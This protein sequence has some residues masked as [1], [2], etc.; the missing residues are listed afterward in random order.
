MGTI[1]DRCCEKCACWMSR[2]PDEN[3]CN[4][5]GETFC[6]CARSKRRF[7]ISKFGRQPARRPSRQEGSSG[8]GGSE[9]DESENASVATFEAA[10][11]LRRRS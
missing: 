1:M 6:G 7:S 3:R 5:C 2:K 10:E 4:L 9:G 8:D 11:K